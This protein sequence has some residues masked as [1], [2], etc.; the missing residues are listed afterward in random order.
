MKI[1]NITFIATFFIIAFVSLQNIYAEQTKTYYAINEDFQIVER[2]AVTLEHAYDIL[3]KYIKV[4]KG[5][6]GDAGYVTSRSLFG[7]SV[8]DKNFIEIYVDD[9]K[10][11]RMMFEYVDNSQPSF[12]GSSGIYQKEIK[13]STKDKLKEIINSFFTHKLDEFKAYYDGL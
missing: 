10:T 8:D 2:G 1:K 7:F 6:C 11:Y 9:E 5:L 4:Q 3:E 12:A 13:V